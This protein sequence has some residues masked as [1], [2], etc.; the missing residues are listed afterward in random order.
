MKL[1]LFLLLTPYF[2]FNFNNEK[3]DKC[4][5]I[6]NFVFGTSKEQFKN[7]TLEIEQGNSQLYTIDSGTLKIDGV[8]L[9]YLGVSFIKNKLSTVSVST[10]NFTGAAFF[11]YLKENYGTPIK[12]KN[13]F[14]W[15]GKHITIIL[16]LYKNNKDASIDFY[17]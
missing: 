2:T 6:G 5:G 9:D 4:N 8:Q 7:M 15:R 16:E 1:F 3:L 10:K 11:K 17:S 12:T 14:E 13:Q